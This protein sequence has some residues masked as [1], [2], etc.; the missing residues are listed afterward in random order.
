MVAKHQ[1]E[2][3]KA[4]NA[5]KPSKPSPRM[6]RQGANELRTREGGGRRIPHEEFLV[7]REPSPSGR[8]FAVANARR[9]FTAAAAEEG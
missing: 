8:V 5:E 4:A 9:I 1:S 2:G 3:N 6:A 7:L